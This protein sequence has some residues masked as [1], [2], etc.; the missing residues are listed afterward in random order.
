MK[1][2][3]YIS[4]AQRIATLWGEAAMLSGMPSEEIYELFIQIFFTSMDAGGFVYCLRSN[5]ITQE[6][7]RKYKKQMKPP[8]VRSQTFESNQERKAVADCMESID[9]KSYECKKVIEVGDEIL[10]KESKTFCFSKKEYITKGKWYTVMELRDTGV[11]SFT[12]ITTTNL[13]GEQNWQSE[14]GISVIR[15]NGKIIWDRWAGTELAHK[16]GL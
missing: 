5:Q 14:L 1:V 9:Q 4:R 3:P 13:A 16:E 10:E 2:V 7:L 11:C 15:R 12:A 8:P 6:Q